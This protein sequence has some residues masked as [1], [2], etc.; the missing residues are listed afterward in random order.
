MI[1]TLNLNV[2]GTK[3]DVVTYQRPDKFPSIGDH[4]HV[5]PTFEHTWGAPR[6]TV[7]G[8]S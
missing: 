2:S 1:K 3:R 4:I 7:I 6:H 5:T 8:G